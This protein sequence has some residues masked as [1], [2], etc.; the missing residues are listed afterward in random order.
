MSH[1]Q[2]CVND[3]VEDGGSEY[4]DEDWGS[5]EPDDE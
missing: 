2:D 4:A 5:D 3:I 1:D